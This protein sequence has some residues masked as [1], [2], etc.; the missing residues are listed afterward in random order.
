MRRAGVLVQVLF[1][2]LPRSYTASCSA[3]DNA[4]IARSVTP[5]GVT[6]PANADLAPLVRLPSPFR[7]LSLCIG[8]CLGCMPLW[9]RAVDHLYVNAHGLDDGGSLRLVHGCAVD[10]MG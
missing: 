2:M 1:K 4:A 9:Y 5:P 7:K 8:C 10:H 3:T 6:V